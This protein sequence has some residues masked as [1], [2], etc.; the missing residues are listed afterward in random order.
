MLDEACLET[1]SGGEEK[2]REGGERERGDREKEVGEF[3]GYCL[4]MDNN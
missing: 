4:K 3:S 2:E 1:G